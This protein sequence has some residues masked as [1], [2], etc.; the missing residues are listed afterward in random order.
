MTKQE[1]EQAFKECK[2]FEEKLKL[3]EK[4]LDEAELEETA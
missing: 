3:L 1:F 4:Q 2:T